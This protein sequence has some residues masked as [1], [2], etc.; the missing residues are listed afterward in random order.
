MA[1]R[2]V[3]IVE[4]EEDR[5][6]KKSREITEIDDKIKTLAADMLETMQEKNGVGLAAPQVGVLKRI[7]VIDVGEGPITLINPV[8]A[9]QKG[10][11]R[12]MEGC[13][14]VP[15][16]WGIVERPEQVIVRGMNLD[17][18]TVEY[19]ADGLLARAFCHEIDHLNGTLYTDK[20]IEYVNPENV[21]EEA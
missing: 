12:E 13:L 9:Y 16:V 15:G 19:K 17:G 21:V 14:S 6:R 8:V 10:A 7:I 2:N 5:L 4:N 3:L 18:E 20:V 1:L 11:I